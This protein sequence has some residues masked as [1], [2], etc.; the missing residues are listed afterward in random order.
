MKGDC[1]FP[2]TERLKRRED[3]K[4]VFKSGVSVSCPGAKL[5]FLRKEGT[6]RRIVFTFPRKFGNAVARNRARRLGREAYRHLRAGIEGGCD[7][8]LLVYPAAPGNGGTK[9]DLSLRMGQMKTL[10]GKAGLLAER[11]AR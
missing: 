11:A 9:N 5:F 4:A 7:M 8:A 6:K 1:K 10:L 2:Q 3:V